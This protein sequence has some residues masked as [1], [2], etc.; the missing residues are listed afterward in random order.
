[1][2]VELLPASKQPDCSMRDPIEEFMIFNRPF[3]QRNPDLLRLKVARMAETALAF[4]RG[5]FHLYAR[6]VIE[7]R[8]TWLPLLSG[9]GAELDLVGDIHSE[10]YGTY[11]AKDGLIHYDVNDFDETTQ[12]RFDVDIC[13]LATSLLLAAQERSDPLT[14]V[15]MAPLAALATYTETVIPALKKS[16]DLDYDIDEDK[17][18]PYSPVADLVAAS[19]LAKRPAFITR[20]TE[21]KNGRRRI[22]RSTHYFNLTDAE[23]DQAVRLL[24]DYR[25]RLPNPVKAKDYYNVE[26]VCGRVSGIGSMGRLRY[27]VLITGK[28]TA[29]GRNVLIEFKEARQSAYDLCRDRATGPDS[30]A[31]RAERVIAMQRLSQAVASAHLGYAVDGDKSFQAREIGP[32][33][34]RVD[35]RSL[36]TPELLHSVGRAQGA[37]L[38]RVHGRSAQRAVG[39]TNPLAE[40]ADPN[41]FCQNVL[42]FALGYADQVRRDYARFIGMRAEIENV[43]NWTK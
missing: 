33:Y 4:F 10:N 40:F 1:M 25:A 16:R 39:P 30:L 13:R 20:L 7:R 42:A 15:V 6:D 18:G 9:G 43:S 2:C 22:L 19:A 14:H 24:A 11:K 36:E 37:L 5:T 12:G 21:L 29:E 26:D 34:A 28:G 27:V 35:T 41:A 38:A 31:K 8:N 23:R 3:A 17:P 32:S